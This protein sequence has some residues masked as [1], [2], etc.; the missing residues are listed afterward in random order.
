MVQN[1]LMYYNYNYINYRDGSK[2]YC[3]TFTP[4][5][6]HINEIHSYLKAYITTICH[7]NNC[8]SHLK[9]APNHDTH[10]TSLSV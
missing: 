4:P 5:T 7:Y 1:T 9:G 2:V 8:Y 3:D 6:L 10:Q